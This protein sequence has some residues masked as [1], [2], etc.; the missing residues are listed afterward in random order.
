[1]HLRAFIVVA[2]DILTIDRLR[3]SPVWEPELTSRIAWDE[4]PV[5][6]PYGATRTPISRQVVAVWEYAKGL[7]RFRGVG[8]VPV[9]N[10]QRR[11]MLQSSSDILTMVKTW[12]AWGFRSEASE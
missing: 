10:K 9:E 12:A 2:Y 3:S 11:L 6:V 8:V 7:S 4:S 5:T 1:M